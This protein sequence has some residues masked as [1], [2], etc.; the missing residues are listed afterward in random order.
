MDLQGKLDEKYGKG[1]VAAMTYNQ[2]LARNIYILEAGGY[3]VSDDNGNAR[4]SSDGVVDNMQFMVDLALT[5]AWKTPTDLG[6]GWNGEAFG[7]GK[8]AIMEEG[9]WVYTTLKNDYSDIRFG[10]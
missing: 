6:L 4:L 9:N 10:V 1:Q 8:A 3:S 2:D 5:G 7:V